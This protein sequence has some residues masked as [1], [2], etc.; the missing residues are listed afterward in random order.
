MLISIA[1]QNPFKV[2]NQIWNE[3]IHNNTRSMNLQ[4]LLPHSLQWGEN[5]TS[6]A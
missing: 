6:K 1:L 2:P 5:E 4:V 3:V